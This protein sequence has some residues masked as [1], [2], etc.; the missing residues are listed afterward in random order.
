[1][2][3]V[4][5]LQQFELRLF[6]LCWGDPLAIGAQHGVSLLVMWSAGGFPGKV[7]RADRGESGRGE[8]GCGGHSAGA[9]EQPSKAEQRLGESCRGESLERGYSSAAFSIEAKTKP[10][11]LLLPPLDAARSEKPLPELGSPP[12]CP[13][14]LPERPLGLGARLGAA[15]SMLAVSIILLLL[16]GDWSLRPG[17]LHDIFDCHMSR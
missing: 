15:G 4:T 2:A 3:A 8:R 5:P 11:G 17:S 14:G 13:R 7:D 9:V 12:R 10:R 6:G 1:M 16:A